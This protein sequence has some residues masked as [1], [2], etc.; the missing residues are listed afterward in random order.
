[1]RVFAQTDWVL[2]GSAAAITLLGILSMYSFGGDNAF[3]PR[4]MVWLG[5]GLVA[6]FITSLVDWRF[7]RRTVS[8]VTIYGIAVFFLLLLFVIG[9]AFSRSA[10]LV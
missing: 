1:M 4:Q 8:V 10:K 5:V 2:V 3:A 9:S 7:L 6:F